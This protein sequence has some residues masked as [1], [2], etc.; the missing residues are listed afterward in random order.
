MKLK[1]CI[2]QTTFSCLLFLYS[3]LA[4]VSKLTES[5]YTESEL[6]YMGRVLIKISQETR[7]REYTDLKNHG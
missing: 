6:Y 7:P 4:E 2:L 1:E 5:Y 3:I